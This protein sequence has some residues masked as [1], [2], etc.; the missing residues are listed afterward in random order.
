MIILYTNNSL[1][2][3]GKRWAPD[4]ERRPNINNNCSRGNM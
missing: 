1:K 2:L 3:I 4:G